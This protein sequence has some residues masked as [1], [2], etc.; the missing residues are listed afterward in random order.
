M[1]NQG[2]FVNKEFSEDATI[3]RNRLFQ[4]SKVLHELGNYAKV[5]HKKVFYKNEEGG[6]VSSQ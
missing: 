3:I 4:R 2:T 5:I 6:D 1:Q